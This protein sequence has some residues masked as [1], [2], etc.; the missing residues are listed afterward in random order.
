MVMILAHRGAHQVARENTVEA[1]CEARRL[2]VDGV[3]L[4]VRVSADGAL[5]V[6]HDVD[7]VGLGPIAALPVADLPA[8]VPL[9]EAAMDAC[10]NLVVNIELKDLPGEPGYDPGHSLAR[11]VA[12]FVVDRSSSAGPR[13]GRVIVSSFDLSALDAARITDPSLKTGWLT[14]KWFDQA[15]ALETLR[16]RGHSRLHPHHE[17]A[18]ETLI[19]AAHEAGI[20][21]TAWTADDP[22]TLRRLAAASVDAIITNDPIG[23][24]ATL[25]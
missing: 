16:E 23:A 22:A 7:I 15:L 14:P 18:T 25:A 5:V 6:H 4:D 3:E 24:R 13:A 8:Y 19:T 2:G 21:V 9:L 10:G 1:F 17:V 12:Q 20:M 11:R